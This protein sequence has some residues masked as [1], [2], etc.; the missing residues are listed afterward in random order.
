MKK[1]YVPLAL[2]LAITFDTA[3]SQSNDLYSYLI[4][5]SEEYSTDTL[6][7]FFY[8]HW[9]EDDSH[10]V[11][12]FKG[13]EIREE[14]AEKLVANYSFE[15]PLYILGYFSITPE[16]KGFLIRHMGMYSA[17][18]ISLIIEESTGNLSQP[19]RIAQR[20][21]DGA[22]HYEVDSW[23][24]DINKDGVKDIFTWR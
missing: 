22:W 11:I 20:G 18:Q 17:N 15:A 5:N 10:E 6:Q 19:I 3:F 8:R 4:E 7:V 9:Y 13:N 24:F 16:Q 14:Y 12:K 23:F 1:Y 2:F 21:G